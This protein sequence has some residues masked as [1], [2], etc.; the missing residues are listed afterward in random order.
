VRKAVVRET[1]GF[2][3]NVI[4]ID[5]PTAWQP[6]EGCYCVDA[7]KDGSPG[8]TWNGAKFIRP[9]PEPVIPPRDLAA[10][11]DQLKADLQAIKT[12]VGMK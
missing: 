1:D 3:V 8:D 4:E 12:K 10:E 7:E 2:V 6:P 5:F 9:E 11:V